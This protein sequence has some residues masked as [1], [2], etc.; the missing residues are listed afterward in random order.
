[1]AA[2]TYN[3]I[4]NCTPA[5]FN[6]AMSTTLPAFGWTAIQAPI[7]FSGIAITGAF[8]TT[9]TTNTSTALTAIASTAGWYVGMGITG[10]GIQAGT[11]IVSFTSTTAVLS[12][13]TTTSVA[14]TT[15]TLAATA[16][17]NQVDFAYDGAYFLRFFD[18]GP[19]APL[20]QAQTGIPQSQ[21][22]PN[23]IAAVTAMFAPTLGAPIASNAANV[24]GPAA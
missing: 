19:A 7:K 18:A 14:G 22:T 6:T 23:F 13:A 10:S 11:T 17:G 3:I 1:M 24:P 21:L 8:T 16:A 20:Q 9:A 15:V 2:Q 5:Q 12:L 4:F